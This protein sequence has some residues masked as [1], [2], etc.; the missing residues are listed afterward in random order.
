MKQAVFQ[1]TLAFPEGTPPHPV[2]GA[3]ESVPAAELPA[4]AAPQARRN[5]R[6]VPVPVFIDWYRRK[7]RVDLSSSLNSV[8]QAQVTV[9][10]LA[11]NK[12]PLEGT[13]QRD[14]GHE[15]RYL[16]H[17]G[18]FGCQPGAYTPK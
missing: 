4:P 9:R 17:V 18:N 13:W 15:A 6:L 11:Q 5:I 8:G 7:F 2:A 10:T 16:V 14:Q 12:Y 3:T 1:P